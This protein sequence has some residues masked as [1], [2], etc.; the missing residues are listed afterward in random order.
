MG[1]CAGR[2]HR[3]DRAADHTRAPHSRSIE[4][5]HWG[6]LWSQTVSSYLVLVEVP[7]ASVSRPLVAARPAQHR[8][9]ADACGPELVR[10]SDASLPQPPLKASVGQPRTSGD[11]GENAP[12]LKR[13]TRSSAGEDSA[14]IERLYGASQW[15]TIEH[16]ERRAPRPPQHCRHDGRLSGASPQERASS[17]SYARPE[18]R[19]VEKGHWGALGSQT[20]PS[21]LVLVEVLSASVSRLLLASRPAQHRLAADACGPNWCLFQML[22][23]RSRR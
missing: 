8:L 23:C 11:E 13:P 18:C 21:Y 14:L 3:K 22:P 5:G 10:V 15:G 19:S 7:S 20:V 12:C 6:A 2:R 9:A 16:A 4:K 17:R 1:G